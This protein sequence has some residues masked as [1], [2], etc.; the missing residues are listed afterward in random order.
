MLSPEQVASSLFARRLSLIG[1][2]ATVTRDFHLAEDLFQE[3]CVKAIGQAA[4][5]Q[6]EAHLF[7]WTR[8]TARNRA[9]DTLR[10]TQGRYDGL[11]DETLEALAAEW[12]DSPAR[13]HALEV[14]ERCLRK[15]TP[16]NRKLLRMRYFEEHSCSEVAQRMQRKIE[17]VYQALA[18]IHKTLGECM[19][20]QNLNEAR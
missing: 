18:R 5:F 17:S 12:P 13:D 7:H 8:L 15:V 20:A 3:T 4:E 6:T 10:R 1:F 2:I 9:I 16:N 14:L 19:R 11:S